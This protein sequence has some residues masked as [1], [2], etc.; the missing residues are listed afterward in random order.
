MAP[1]SHVGE[2]GLLRSMMR[3]VPMSSWKPSS[4]RARSELR[5]AEATLEEVTAA[6]IKARANGS[7]GEAGGADWRW[8]GRFALIWQK[9]QSP[10][11]LDAR[12]Q[13]ARDMPLLAACILRTG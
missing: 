10:S 1:L 13:G 8:Q 3:V 9:C 5:R 2:C 7:D 4:E 12:L 6:K 11:L